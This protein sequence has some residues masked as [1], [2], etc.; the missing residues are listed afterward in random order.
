MRFGGWIVFAV[1]SCISGDATTQGQDAGLRGNGS[2]RQRYGELFAQGHLGRVS[3]VLGVD[4]GFQVSF[5]RG[6]RVPKI[7]AMDP[8][9]AR[10]SRRYEQQRSQ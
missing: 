4:S 3:L 2:R 8:D 9:V 6:R 10:Y 7:G 1:F 5:L